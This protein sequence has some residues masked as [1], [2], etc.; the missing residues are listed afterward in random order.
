M[1][2][3]D[4]MIT[5]NYIANLNKSREQSLEIQT[6]LATNSKINKPSDSPTGI[7]KSIQLSSQI[8]NTSMYS[9]NIGN[10]KADL[11]VTT[12]AMDSIGEQ[13]TTVLTTLSNINNAANDTTSQ[14]SA[15]GDTIDTALSEIFNA[16][17]SS[18]NGK[19]VFS[20]TD[21]SAKP[22]AYSSDGKTVQVNVSDISGEQVIRTASHIYQQIN[23]TGAEVFG[24]NVTVSGNVD[25][26]KS[27]AQDSTTTVYDNSGN[28]YNL[29]VTYTKTA[30]NT[31]NMKYDVVDQS[32]N[33]VTSD[34][35]SVVF[36]STTGAMSTIDGK[37]ASGITVNNTDKGINFVLDTTNVT[38]KAQTSSISY[39]A[40]QQTTI[41]NTLIQIRD[42]LKAGKKPTQAEYATV[43]AFS[44][45]L[46]TKESK[47]GNYVNS[48]ETTDDLLTN[49]TTE[50]KTLL[51]GVKDV[52]QYQA[53]I[54]LEKTNYQLQLSYKV[55]SMVMNKSLL[56]YL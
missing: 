42:E 34:T 18:N 40:D 51:S 46:L 31:Y 3:T 39:S 44:N 56:D 28:K 27:G 33:S 47:A 16:A 20:G 1:R 36:D 29:N 17:N 26:T 30:D 15:F 45:R 7:A 48:L 38:E 23:V 21:N 43:E 19:F 41:F 50:L 55:A 52:D 5:G 54:D 24:T 11:Q 49:Q 10:A 37:D 12:T 4:N 25:S 35:K 8:S 53:V 6:Q 2:V 14:L 13:I 22:F 9:D 32:G